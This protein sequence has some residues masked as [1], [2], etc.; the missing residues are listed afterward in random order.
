MEISIC[1]EIRTKKGIEYV[2]RVRSM[3]EY[4]SVK[5]K[6]KAKREKIL[7]SWVEVRKEPEC[8]FEEGDILA[9]T[10]NIDR[11]DNRMNI[12]R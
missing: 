4:E 6:I 1:I 11:V 8:L 5:N 9:D 2:W 10:L 3:P 7:S 12:E